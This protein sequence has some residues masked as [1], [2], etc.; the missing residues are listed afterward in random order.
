MIHPAEQIDIAQSVRFAH[1]ACV[2]HPVEKFQHL[3]RALAEQ[4]ASARQGAERGALRV[5]RRQ[6]EA[7]L[8]ERNRCEDA[9]CVATAY[10]R[11]LAGYSSPEPRPTWTRPSRSGGWAVSACRS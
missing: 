8:S 2:A 6:Q 9:A 4:W 1:A 7:L 5:M 10:R 11:Y 3:H